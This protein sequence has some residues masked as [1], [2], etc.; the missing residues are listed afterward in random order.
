MMPTAMSTPP[1]TRA[2]PPFFL[3]ATGVETGYMPSSLAHRDLIPAPIAAGTRDG[4]AGRARRGGGQP[5]KRVARRRI[6]S[7]G[8]TA[9]RRTWPAAA[10]P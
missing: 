1:R 6:R 4:R 3:A 2:I 10:S 7:V 5:P 9:A 8:W